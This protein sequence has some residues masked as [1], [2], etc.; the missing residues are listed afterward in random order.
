MRRLTVSLAFA[1]VLLLAAGAAITLAA[2]ADASPA[3]PAA[4]HGG[5]MAATKA[6]A[7]E[8]VL[9]PFG[10][11]VYLYSDENGPAMVEKATGTATL[12][13]PNG[14]SVEAKLA[15]EVPGDKEPATY[16]CPM[17]VEVVQDQPGECKLCGGMKLFKQDRLFG[18]ADLSKVKL[19][20]VKVKI[21][22]TGMRG[23]EKEA[24]FTPAF[25]APDGKAEGTQS[26]EKMKG[27]CPMTKEATANVAC[28][29]TGKACPM[30]KA[31]SQI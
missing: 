9:T 10:V 7:F 5:V 18:S 1:F 21:H 28:P 17:H 20:D 6:H 29:S 24:T 3:S 2:G 19:A 11:R 27:G 12:T 8:T 25:P 30:H 4:R 15:A 16:F 14:K 22:V 13:L 26:G 31:D 23:P